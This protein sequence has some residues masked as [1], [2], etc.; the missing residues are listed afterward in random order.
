M[1]DLRGRGVI[2]KMGQN[3][4]FVSLATISRSKIRGVR[5]VRARSVPNGAASADAGSSKLDLLSMVDEPAETAPLSL[6]NVRPARLTD[7]SRMLPLLNEYARRAEILPRLEEDVYRSIR[8]W[9]LAEAEG[10]VIGMGSLLIMWHD[11]AEI[12]SLVIDPAY[13]GQGVGRKV[14]EVLL[15]QARL[16]GLPRVFALTRKP[17]FFLKLGFQLTRIETLPRKV[18]KDCV[19]CPKFHACDEVAVVMSLEEALPVTSCP[20]MSII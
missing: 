17:G 15:G 20:T 13:Q 12:R 9:V 16:L 2:D 3:D 14:V 10:R 5:H 11:L 8:E 19:F 6:L 7:V 18:H 1:G 4:R